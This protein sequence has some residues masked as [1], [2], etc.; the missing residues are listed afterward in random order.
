MINNYN[1]KLFREIFLS[2]LLILIAI[3][4]IMNF[5]IR[6]LFNVQILLKWENYKREN[7]C[8]WINSLSP[9]HEAKYVRSDECSDSWWLLTR[10]KNKL[11]LIRSPST[12][13]W[14]APPSV[15][16]PGIQIIKTENSVI[17]VPA[18]SK[19][20]CFVVNR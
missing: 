2:K 17:W 16:W 18:L 9:W 11:N 14:K 4:S 12:R 20:V 7:E 13:T 6:C 5:I 15:I 3:S 19:A 10:S 8:K 1:K